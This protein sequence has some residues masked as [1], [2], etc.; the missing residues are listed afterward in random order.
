M[1][2]TFLLSPFDLQSKAV[3]CEVLQSKGSNEYD[4]R[5]SRKKKENCIWM[6]EKVHRSGSGSI[7]ISNDT[8]CVHLLSPTPLAKF[9]SNLHSSLQTVIK[10]N[11]SL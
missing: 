8:R 2:E 10:Q 5:L 11:I 1:Y 7:A 4:A 6:V 9:Q 3:L